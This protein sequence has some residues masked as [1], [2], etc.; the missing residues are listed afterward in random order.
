MSPIPNKTNPKVCPTCGSRLGE[1]ATRCLVCGRNILPATEMIGA[2]TV[3]GA[4]MPEIT[5][6]LPIA[7]VL[8][9]LLLAIGAGTVFGVLRSTGKV[10]EPTITPTASATVTITL[11]PT[12]SLTSTPIPTFTP[13]PPVEYQVQPNDTC[14]SIAFVFKI[15]VASIVTLNNLPAECNTLSIGQKLQIP[16]PTPTPSPMPTSTLSAA[17]AT[18]AACEKFDY[19]VKEND[20]LSTIAANYNVEMDAIREYNGL[21]NDIVYQG[22]KLIIPLC[23][24]KPTAGATPTATPPPPYL[25]PNLLLPADGSVFQAANDTI[26]LQWAVVGTLRDNEAYAITIEDITDGTGKKIVEYVTDT[27]YI[28][29]SSMRPTDNTAHIFRWTVYA[30]RQ[31]GTSSD[32]NPVWEAGGAISNPRVFSWTGGGELPTPTP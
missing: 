22:Q 31:A 30:V 20:T 16:Q 5:L 21:P 7:L 4:R 10:V 26:T 12:A 17:E 27:K 1:N 6:S 23:A 8:L 25:A 2:K 9:L 11:T 32:G 24:R 29:P 28:V 15:S 3:K 14:L 19:E 18:E 13:L